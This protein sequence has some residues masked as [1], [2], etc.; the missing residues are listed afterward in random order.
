MSITKS[1]NH[2]LK[3][4]NDTG[5]SST[6]VTNGGRFINRDGTYNLRKT[7]W[8]VW[9][10]ISL[11]HIMISLP[12]WQFITV[13]V[14]FFLFINFIYAGIYALIGSDQFTGMLA[15]SG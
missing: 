6:G 1:I 14:V 4:N 3:M 15:T 8:P 10:R 11:Y 7:G 5:F 13:I 2:H 12:L 9:D